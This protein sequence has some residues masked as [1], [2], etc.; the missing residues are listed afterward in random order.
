MHLNKYICDFCGRDCG[1]E[2][3][4]V[5]VFEEEMIY[6][7]DMYG[8][9]VCSFRDEKLVIKHVNLCRDC[10]IK[11][12]RL[13]ELAKYTDLNKHAICIMNKEEV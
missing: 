6:A 8:A 4:I 3:Y 9:K 7:K 13:M 11:L 2:E 5:P 1:H 12:A 10:K